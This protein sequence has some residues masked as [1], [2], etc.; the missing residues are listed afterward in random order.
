WFFLFGPGKQQEPE[1]THFAQFHYSFVAPA[2][3]V[4]TEDNAAARQVVIKSANH[5][6][7]NDLVVV[8]ENELSY[9]A[10]RKWDRFAAE[11]REK[12]DDRQADRYS[13][14][15]GDTR[16]AG[17]RAVSFTEHK[18]NATVAWYALASGSF[19]VLVGCQYT[20]S[21]QRVLDACEQVVSTLEI[22]Q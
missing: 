10:A 18:S 8:Q 17:K 20:E 14:F 6:D 5:T 16:Y 7:A 19:E 13:D 22:R 15:D 2:G 3:W 12:I 1:G 21:E 4:Q 11:L 9:D